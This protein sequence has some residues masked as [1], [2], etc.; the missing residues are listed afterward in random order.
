MNVLQLSAGAPAIFNTRHDASGS[1]ALMNAKLLQSKGLRLA[2][3]DPE[4]SRDLLS[5][6]A[7]AADLAQ[8]LLGLAQSA[9][10]AP[11]AFSAHPTAPITPV[12]NLTAIYAARTP[13]AATLTATTPTATRSGQLPD[14]HDIYRQ[15][16]QIQ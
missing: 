10:S 9:P 5:L 2:Q 8:K 7:I 11:A 14:P 1:V 3:S 13:E 4:Q 12:I 16:G 15:R 6:A